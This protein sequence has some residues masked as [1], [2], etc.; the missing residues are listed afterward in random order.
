[1]VAMSVVKEFALVHDA[2]PRF[3]ASMEDSHCCITS[4]RGND[5]EALFA[6][7][8]GHGG[9]D[10]ADQLADKFPKVFE[11]KRA[12]VS[13]L[14]QHSSFDMWFQTYQDLDKALDPKLMAFQGAAA[15]AAYVVGREDGSKVV[16]AS[17]VGDARAVLAHGGKVD[18]VTRDHKASEKS[19]IDRIT[20]LGGFVIA[21]RVQGILSV[22]RALGD[23][24]LK[25]YVSIEPYATE[26]II[27]LAELQQETPVILIVACDGLWDVFNDNEAISIVQS[28]LGELK[29]EGKPLKEQVYRAAEHLMHSALQNGSTD[30]ISIIVALL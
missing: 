13:D 27:P 21:S 11:N 16:Y 5:S 29:K 8:D 15:V 2:N 18:R 30:N 7:F 20:E 10:A 28:K 26:N 1:M 19:E 3:R 14:N 4:F 12:S 24:G 17:N 6:V 23:H 9:K 25:P 22:S